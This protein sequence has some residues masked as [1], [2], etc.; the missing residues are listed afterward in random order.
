MRAFTV[1][2]R[3][4][5]SPFWLTV[6]GNHLRGLPNVRVGNDDH[7]V[8]MEKVGTVLV[9]RGGD[10]LRISAVGDTERELAAARAALTVEIATAVPELAEGRRLSLEWGVPAAVPQALRA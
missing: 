10:F 2:L 9:E 6:I 1:T 7:L 8:L 5:E 4:P 3:S